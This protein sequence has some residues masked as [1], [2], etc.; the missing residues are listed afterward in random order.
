MRSMKITVYTRLRNI[1]LLSI[2]DF[3]NNSIIKKI[4]PTNS[5]IFIKTHHFT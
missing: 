5:W 3:L 1:L 4:T 2:K